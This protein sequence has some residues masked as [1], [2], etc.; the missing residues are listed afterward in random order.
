MDAREEQQGGAE[1][2]QL[3]ESRVGG[4]R[5]IAVQIKR[6]VGSNSATERLRNAVEIGLG[7]RVRAG[8][9]LTASAENV[10]N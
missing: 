3:G 1:P 8:G 4:G 5:R 2:L 7:E 10:H 9:V 6:P